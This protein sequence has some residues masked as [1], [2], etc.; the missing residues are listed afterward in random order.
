MQKTELAVL[1]KGLFAIIALA[2]V[3]STGTVAFAQVNNNAGPG[4][5]NGE[6]AAAAAEQFNA[7]YNMYTEDFEADI[8]AL[9]AQAKSELTPEGD[10]E[11][12]Q[13]NLIFDAETAELNNEVATAVEDFRT[14]VLNA[15][16]IAE[17]KDEFINLFNQAKAEY[18][19][20]LDAA[21]NDF[22]N[23]IGGMGHDANVTK[24]RFMNGF[25]S[26]RDQ[27]S[28]DL[29]MIKNEFAAIVSNL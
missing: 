15:A 26:R 6:A 8:D 13:F 23:D 1:K 10:A 28:N 27:Y 21:K 12:E 20:A 7:D 9:V 18:L 22:A 2:V 17:S 11:I 16:N 4:Y 3:I 25:N 19:N 5:G 14:K 29:E 24:D